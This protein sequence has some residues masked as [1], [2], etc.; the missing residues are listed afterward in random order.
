MTDVRAVM[1]Q[2]DFELTVHPQ[3]HVPLRGNGNLGLYR[4]V[5][6]ET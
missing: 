1:R 4:L 2:A 6:E 5:D 3:G